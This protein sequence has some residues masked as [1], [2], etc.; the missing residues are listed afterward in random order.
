MKKNIPVFAISQSI[1]D[2]Y[3][4]SI[5]AKTILE[6]SYTDRMRVKEKKDEISLYTGIQRPLNKTRINEI[7]DYVQTVDASFPTSIII[8]LTEDCAHIIK[9]GDSL[10]LQLS[11]VSTNTIEDLVK[12]GFIDT[13]SIETAKRD[14]LKTHG[15]AKVLDGQHRLAGLNAAIQEVKEEL[16][17]MSFEQDHEK[18]VA[19]E[20]QLKQL[21]SFQFNVSIFIGY[22]IHSQAMLFSKVNLAQTK[23]NPS[24]VYN[25]ETY[26]KL[27]T[28]QRIAHNLAKFLDETPSSPFYQTIKMLGHKTEGRQNKEFLSQATFVEATM[29]LLSKDPEKERDNIKR[30]GIF[31]KSKSLE[32]SE[33]DDKKYIFN[34]FIRNDEIGKIADILHNYFSVIKNKWSNAWNNDNYLLS[35][36]NCFRALMLYLRT[37]YNEIGKEVPSEKDFFKVFERFDLKSTDFKSE[38][39]PHGDGGMSKFYKYLIGKIQYNDLFYPDTKRVK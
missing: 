29:L 1:G 20:N 3:V 9:N 4:A 34:K 27:A 6:I 13:N 23:V 38:I 18:R 5:D 37:A 14:S 24:L 31:N 8:S 36:N 2:F 28:P 10:V 39:F 15:L 17:R 11:E 26:T 21:E 33:E 12:T 35:K 7:K 22:D 19:L 32:Y 30:G 25:L 16:S